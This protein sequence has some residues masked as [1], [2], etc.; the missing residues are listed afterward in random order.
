MPPTHGTNG[1]RTVRFC[2]SSW[3]DVKPVSCWL[4]WGK[5]I[6]RSDVPRQPHTK[7][8]PQECRAERRGVAEADTRRVS[9]LPRQFGRLRPI[10]GPAGTRFTRGCEICGFGRKRPPSANCP[11]SLEQPMIHC[12]TMYQAHQGTCGGNA[13]VRDTDVTRRR[14]RQVAQRLLI[15]VAIPAHPPWSNR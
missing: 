15:G 10:V 2:A 11:P 8:S 6:R 9:G 3:T 7:Y 4:S 14:P 12:T 5:R 1:H 13:R